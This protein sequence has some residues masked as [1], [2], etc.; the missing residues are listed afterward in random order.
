MTKRRAKELLNKLKK[1]KVQTTLVL[2]YKKRDDS[3]SNFYEAFKCIHQKNFSVS[4][5]RTNSIKN[6]E[7]N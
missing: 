2:E 5:R 1:L 6:G 7:N 3:D 4:L